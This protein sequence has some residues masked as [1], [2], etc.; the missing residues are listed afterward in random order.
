MSILKPESGLI[1]QNEN[2]NTEISIVLDNYYLCLSV[3]LITT[4]VP[5][6]RTKIMS[7][8]AA[9]RKKKCYKNT[10]RSHRI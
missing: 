7:K 6:T 2:W 10:R 5:K 4:Y 9:F 8:A 1:Y 3:K